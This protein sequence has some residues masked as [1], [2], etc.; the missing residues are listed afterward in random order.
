MYKNNF[1]K[2]EVASPKITLGSPKDN[3]L[4]ILQVL[5]KSKSSILLFPELTLSGYSAGDY[6][7]Q[8]EFL[9]ECIL[10]LETI[11]NESKYTGLYTLGLPL[12]NEG[13]LLNVAVVI[14]ENEIIGV[15]PKYHLPNAN[16]YNEKRWFDS[17][18]RTNAKQINIL[19]KNVPFGPIIFSDN[20]ANLHIGIEICEDLWSLET[21]SDKLVAQGANVILNLSSSSEYLGKDISRRNLIQAHSLKQKGLYAYATTGVSESVSDVLFTNY[22]AI[23]LN[24]KFLVETKELSINNESIV[25]DLYIPSLTYYRNQAR[26]DLYGLKEVGRVAFKLKETNDYELDYTFSKDPF[27]EESSDFELATNIQKISLAQK[28]L[29]LPKSVNKI[30]LGLSGGLDSTLALLASVEAYDY[31]KLDR[32][33]IVAV[34]MP[35]KHTSKR[36]IS[37]AKQLALSLEVTFLEINIEDEVNLHLNL[38]DHETKDNTYENVQA[39]IRTMLLMNLANK[40]GGFVL[41]TGDLSEIA[42]GFMTYNGDQMSMYAINSGIPKTYAQKLVKYHSDNN[43]YA[44]KDLLK[45]VVNAPI[46]PELNDNQKTEDLIGKYEYN[47]FIL[48]YNL[49]H[50]FDV[51][52]LKFLLSHVFKLD[53]NIANN[54]V[55][56][57]FER[58]NASQFKRQ[59]LP[60]GPKVFKLSLNPRSGYKVASDIK[61]K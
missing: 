23:V 19:G 57:Y 38:I 17:G 4:E 13:L 25:T 3:A 24:G 59:T 42:L 28:I 60:E 40:L 7:Y 12:F 50:G 26:L 11:L 16:E 32:K 20:H 10:G 52:T 61:R 47:D 6:F 36:A 34:F 35:T 15:V 31:L 21:P 48:Y 46:S 45:S 30:I 49:V 51:K 5:N 55:D 18:Y 53:Q 39:R 37:D 43:F 14:F 44:I 8:P 56:A 41:G 33:D 29:S 9:E 58:F 2:I 22:K 54:Y 1:V 27:L